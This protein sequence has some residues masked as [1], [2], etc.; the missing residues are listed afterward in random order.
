MASRMFSRLQVL[1][2]ERKD[3]TGSFQPNG[4][5]TSVSNVF[6]RGFSV[7]HTAGTNTYTITLQDKYFNY[8]SC[9]V[10]ASGP[11]LLFAQVT[12]EPDVKN[13]QAITVG[14]FTAAGAAATDQ[15]FNVNQ[16]VHFAIRVVNTTGNW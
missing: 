6:G 7:A 14:L 4:A 5:A 15:A 9:W 16:R 1:G 13:A 10:Q 11:T 8:D 3:L 12:A 2:N